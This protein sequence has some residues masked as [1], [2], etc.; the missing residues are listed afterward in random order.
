MAFYRARFADASNFTFVF[1]GSFTPD[2]IRPF[3]ET[4]IGSLPATHARETWRDEGITPP[5]GIVEKTIQKGVAPKSQVAIVFTGPFQYDDQHRLALRAATLVLQSR[6]FDTIRQ[7]LGG[8]YNITAVQTTDKSPRPEYEVRIE[9]TCDPARTTDLV[10]RVFRE[11][12]FV[13]NTAVGVRQLGLIREALLRQY[14][15][16][17]QQNGYLLNQIALRYTNGDAANV[18]AALDTPQQVNALTGQAVQDAAH[19]YLDTS[20]YVKVILNPES[21]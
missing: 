7:E 3:V 8:T 6:L 18:Q 2:A 5:R 17:S 13:R 11:I 15:A 10:N 20:N 4:Y 9:W 1:V 12:D 16:D 19:T 21:N 14:E